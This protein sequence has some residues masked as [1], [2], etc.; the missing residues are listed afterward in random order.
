MKRGMSQLLSAEPKKAIPPA[1][2]T[3]YLYSSALFHPRHGELTQRI[4]Q[5]QKEVDNA[6]EWC[7]NFHLEKEIFVKNEILN[8]KGAV[9]VQRQTNTRAEFTV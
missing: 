9:T 7:K 1:F 4:V 3:E 5:P 6:A 8:H 2:S